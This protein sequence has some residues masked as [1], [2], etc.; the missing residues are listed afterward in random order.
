MK[1]RNAIMAMGAIG[2]SVAI[3]NNLQANVLVK[4][5]PTYTYCLN[6]STISGQKPG[7]IK[8]IEITAKAGYDGIEL[9]I[10][11]IKEYLKNGNK[12]TELAKI[13]DSSGLKV[14]NAIG[15][16]P[17]MVDDNEKRRLGLIQLEEEMNWLAA[18]G[19][20]RI[21]APP[22]GVSRDQPIDWMQAGIRYKEALDLGR[23]TGVMPQ[24]E[25]WGASGTLFHLSQAVAI[26]TAANDPDARL[27]PDIYHLFRGGSGFDCLNLI[28]GNTIEIFHFN[29]YVAHIPQ[30]K[31]TDNDRVFP[32]DGI[33]PWSKIMSILNSMHS[34]KV[35]S[36][37]LFNKEYWKQDPLEVAKTGLMKM[38]K[39][40]E[41]GG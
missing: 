21:A 28:A 14:E 11:D 35:L 3:P 31:Q 39:L 38:K 12:L 20:K 13:I 15:F 32:S 19:G 26:A 18:L 36:L 27:L 30:E 23:K 17:W 37:E 1:R 2:A 4:K 16:A 25:F 7:I 9:W 5:R 22:A 29:D 40:V 10:N 41:I 6:T 8:Y 33:A 34:P 24:L